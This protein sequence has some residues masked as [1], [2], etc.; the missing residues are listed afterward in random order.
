VTAGIAQAVQCLRLGDGQQ[1]NRGSI[2]GRSNILLSPKDPSRSGGLSSLVRNGYPGLYTQGN[3]GHPQLVSRVG[4]SGAI[5]PPLVFF[6]NPHR[7]N[8]IALGAWRQRMIGLVKSFTM[9]Y[10]DYYQMVLNR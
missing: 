2:P 3:S 10:Q 9:L 1:R 8:F 4:T 5:P 7:D 6:Y